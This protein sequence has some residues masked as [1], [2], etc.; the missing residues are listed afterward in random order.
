MS[1]VEAL[2]RRILELKKERNAIVLAHYYQRAEIQDAADFV[3]DSLGLSQQAAATD[4][5]VIVFCGV[6]FMAESARILAGARQAV[7]M[8]H[9]GAGCPM[10]DMAPLREAVRVLR[11]SGRL[12]LSDLFLAGPA[13]SFLPDGA[14]A[15]CA[16]GARSLPELRRLSPSAGHAAGRIMGAPI[17]HIVA[18]FPSEEN[19]RA[20]QIRKARTVGR[21]LIADG[22]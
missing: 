22:M 13:P 9:P 18:P 8:P 11:P 6:H 21:L 10:A 2:Q 17:V 3:G 12:L 14:P 4:A 16:C 1:T 20:R 5:D 7:Y 15:S 19:V